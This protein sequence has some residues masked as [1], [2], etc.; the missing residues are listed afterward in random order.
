MAQKSRCSLQDNESD[1][2]QDLGHSAT[3]PIMNDWYV[4]YRQWANRVINV[5]TYA[6]IDSLS[7]RT[8]PGF[9]LKHILAIIHIY[10]LYPALSLS[11]SLTRVDLIQL[12]KSVSC[13]CF[14]SWGEEQQRQRVCAILLIS[15]TQRGRAGD[16]CSPLRNQT[17]CQ[18]REKLKHGN[19][20]RKL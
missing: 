1:K 7:S 16:C 2:V 11:S 9:M 20:N 15:G 4:Y 3:F 6:G 13:W 14:C 10:V 19:C 18:R 8:Y 12:W 5:Y 17:K